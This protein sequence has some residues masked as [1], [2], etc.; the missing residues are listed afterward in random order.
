MNRRT[1]PP[2]W[3]ELSKR[4]IVNNIT[5]I[6]KTI[7]SKKLFINVSANAFGFGIPAFIRGLTAARVGGFFVETLDE[8]LTIRSWGSNLAI[9]VKEKPDDQTAI[10]MKENFITAM[11]DSPSELELKKSKK[12]LMI[13]YSKSEEIKN[14]CL[15]HPYQFT[16][17]NEPYC[18][19]GQPVYSDL[20]PVLSLKTRIAS[21]KDKQATIPLGFKDGFSS[22]FE[23]FEVFINNEISAQIKKVG[24]TS[25]TIQISKS[26]DVGD[27]VT[28]FG[29]KKTIEQAA[30]YQ[31]ISPIEM[32]TRLDSQLPRILKS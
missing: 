9:I 25:S 11:I 3:L 1:E 24:L 13:A 15:N 10:I 22:S 30:N 17:S 28:I 8:A 31:Q 7:G 19:V 21:C 4:A 14:F 20:L 26:I 5:E 23:G 12:S 2:V 27:I 16:M 29:S 32:I 6:K 18:I